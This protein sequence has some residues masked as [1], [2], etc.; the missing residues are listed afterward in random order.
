MKKALAFD[1]GGTKIYSTII[2]ETGS[3]IG[4]I[5]KFSTPKTLD[6]IE[7]ILKEQIQKFENDID[8]V[9]VATAG[10]VNNEN[11]GVIGSTGNLVEGYSK[12]NFQ[13]LSSKPVFVE[14]DANSAAWAEYKIGASKGSSV[15]ILLTLGTGVGGGIII[16]DKLLKGKNGAAG[17]MH[18]KMYSDKR[19]KCT[20]GSWDCFEIYASG[21]ALKIDA[22]EAT[23]KPEITTY[24]VIEGVKNGDKLMISILNR[25]QN[26]IIT[27][28]KGLVNLFD[29]DCIALSGSMAQFTDPEYIEKEVNSDIVTTPTSIKLATAGNYSGM[30]GVALLALGV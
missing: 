11:T 3:I 25:W 13:A 16:N 7:S 18:F 24:D 19:R 30:I 26:D 20:C 17:E 14:N 21:T 12:L 29:P 1:I 22:E 27:G 15:S 6:K 23:K 10:A 8:V 4:T 9:A 28:I 5:D 2:D